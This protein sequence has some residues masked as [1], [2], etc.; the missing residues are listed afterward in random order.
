MKATIAAIIKLC[1]PKKSRNGYPCWQRALI[2]SKEIPTT[3][4]SN[5][6]DTFPDLVAKRPF[7]LWNSVIANELLE[8]AVAKSNMY[9][10]QDKNDQAFELPKRELMRYLG[11]VLLSEHRSLPSE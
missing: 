5:L 1:S 2:F 7:D 11:I 3:P 9:A 8:D 10:K 6:S 4:T